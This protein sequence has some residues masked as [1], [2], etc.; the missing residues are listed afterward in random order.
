MALIK[1]LGRFVRCNDFISHS[2]RT[3]SKA[4]LQSRDILMRFLFLLFTFQRIDLLI[5]SYSVYLRALFFWL[6]APMLSFFDNASDHIGTNLSNLQFFAS[7]ISSFLGS[8]NVLPNV[9]PDG[10]AKLPLYVCC[11]SSVSF[12]RQKDILFLPKT[13]DKI[14]SRRFL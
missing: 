12:L 8:K 5:N 10:S 2:C 7:S 11:Y 1:S 13:I 4:F 9:N 14:T 3:K 6:L